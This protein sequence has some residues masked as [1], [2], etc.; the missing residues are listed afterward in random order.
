MDNWAGVSATVPLVTCGQMNFPRS[1]LFANRHKPSPLHQRTLSKSPRL[2]RK[3][4]HPDRKRDSPP[5]P[6]APSRLQARKSTPQIR[7]SRGDPDACSGTR[8]PLIIAVN[9]SS[10]VRKTIKSL[11]CSAMR[12]FPVGSSILRVPAAVG[13]E[14]WRGFAAGTTISLETVTGSRLIGKGYSSDPAS[15]QSFRHLKIW[16]AF[17][18][19]F[20][21]NCATEESP[22]KLS[23]TI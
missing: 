19:Y 21:A 2:P 6:S 9:T 14:G 3:H 16:F 12:R 23:S 17:T 1:S 20:C 8:H 13:Q 5:A 4:E 22:A 18:A 10:A 7:H 11:R 15:R